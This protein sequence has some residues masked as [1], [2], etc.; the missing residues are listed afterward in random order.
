MMRA[1]QILALAALSILI[2][3][4]GGGGKTYSPTATTPPNQQTPDWIFQLGAQPALKTATPSLAASGHAVKRAT[5]NVPVLIDL[6]TLTPGQTVGP[7]NVLVLA[8]NGFNGT[9]NLSDVASATPDHIAAVPSVASITPTAAGA[10]FSVGFAVPANYP[11]PGSGVEFQGTDAQ[12]R[13]KQE[14]IAFKVS[15]VSG[16]FT[17]VSFVNNV[18]QG[19]G[20]LAITPINGF[21]GPITVTFDTNLTGAPTG[22]LP[23]PGT[24]TVTAPNSPVTISGTTAISTPI[25]F[26][27]TAWAAGSYE[28]IAVLTKGTMAIRVPVQITVTAPSGGTPGAVV[29]WHNDNMRTG[30]YGQ[31]TTLNTSN[32]VSGSFGRLFTQALDAKTEGQPLYVPNIAIPGNGTHNVVYVA[33]VND[34]VYAFD[35]DNATGQNAAPLWHVTVGTAAPLSSESAGNESPDG[36]LS[37]PVIDVNA[38]VMY[39]CAKNWDG[40]TQ[41][42]KLHGLDLSTGA[43]VAGGPVTF[44]AAIPG[45]VNNVTF[46]PNNSYQRPAL[47]LLNGVVYVGVGGQYGDPAPDRGWIF[48]FSEANLT[49]Q[50]ALF[51]TADDIK[52]TA[53]AGGSIWM[54]AAG[55][56]SDGTY[57]YATTGNGDFDANNNGG[58]DYGDTIL[59]LQPS[60]STLTV[61]D[62]FTP[63]NQLALANADLDLGASGPILIPAQGGSPTLLV[64]TCKTNMVYIAN[65]SSMGQ[66]NNASDNIYQELALGVNREYLCTPA[67]YNGAVYMARGNNLAAF[68]IAS[69]TLSSSAL[70]SAPTN[71][72]G[73]YPPTP[74]ISFNSSLSGASQAATA[75]VWAI[76]QNSGNAVL[77]AYNAGTL[78]E[79]FKSTNVSDAAGTFAKWAIPTV[80]NGKVYVPCANELAIY[81]LTSANGTVI[82]KK[83]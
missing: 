80:A 74:T 29:T 15:T 12:S 54:S 62:Y 11:Y 55:L 24:V 22:F 66:F 58:K 46:I 72:G 21:T 39:V 35:A 75:I 44:N 78:A 59:K 2:V 16:L 48:G 4:C 64:Q 5:G 10:P 77:H 32:V 34:S 38:H 17:P 18:G 56:A 51:T 68:S 37:T 23:L 27:W 50:T 3:S 57:I 13:T 28:V 20:P 43:E 81:G 63:F 82:R 33:T 7:I 65:T 9:V 30:Q 6:G 19:S 1:N 31:E 53:M 73:N 52:G 26:T 61:A 14:L 83:K 25:N 41:T 79:L 45:I 47:L 60:G 69:G 8:L 40:E 42:L 71:F 67:Y 70:S 36:V 76:E 49:N